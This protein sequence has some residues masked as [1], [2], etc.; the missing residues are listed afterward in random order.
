MSDDDALVQQ[1]AMAECMDMVREELI[2]AGVV[3]A[4][5][6][7]MMLSNAVLAFIARERAAHEQELAFL[8]RR[9][10]AAQI[11][12]GLPQW[13]DQL[14]GRD[15]TTDD[16]INEVIRLRATVHEWEKLRDPVALHANLMRGEP[17]RLTRPMLRHLAGYDTMPLHPFALVH[18]RIESN[19]DTELAVWN[20]ENYNF[21]D[22]DCYARE[23]DTLEGWSATFLT[24]H[25][26]E[27]R[28]AGLTTAHAQLQEVAVA[29]LRVV[30]ASGIELDEKMNYTV[31]VGALEGMAGKPRGRLTAAQQAA[32]DEALACVEYY[33]SKELCGRVRAVL[34][35]HFDRAYR[36]PVRI[37]LAGIHSA[38]LYFDWAREG[39]GFGQLSIGKDKDGRVSCMNEAMGRAFV[40]DALH[41]AVDVLV[42]AAELEE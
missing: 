7:P 36:A 25:E 19:G 34:D 11:E 42:D 33:E 39:T 37:D 12:A 4:S 10:P 15:P 20:G 18:D 16:L 32:V 21:A 26:L 14:K 29:A 41:A 22:G 8:R 2:E 35:K 27:Q 23:S 5:V 31:L 6:P 28:I 24:H 1:A 17:A 9:Q 30:Q 38:S 3:D 13:I 40:R